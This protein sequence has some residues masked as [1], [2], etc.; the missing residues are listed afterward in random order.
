MDYFVKAVVWAYRNCLTKKRQFRIK[1][2]DGFLAKKE[3]FLSDNGAENNLF[4]N[5]NGNEN[6]RNVPISKEVFCSRHS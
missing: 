4:L 2:I 3:T 5:G 1:G 6:F